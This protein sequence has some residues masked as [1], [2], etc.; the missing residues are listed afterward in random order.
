MGPTAS[1]KTEVAEAIADHFDAQLI[2]ADAF[3]VY[4]GMDIGTAK[5]ECK[6]R[7]RLLDLKAPNEGFGVG[8]FVQLARAELAQLFEVGR[9]AVVVG[10]TGLYIRALF[11]QYTELAPSP[12]PELRAVLMAREAQEGLKSLTDELT[13]R[14]PEISSRVDL[15]NPVRVRRALERL[16]SEPAQKPADLP[17]FLTTKLVLQPDKNE[18]TA[19]IE[20]RMHTMVQNGWLEEVE[21]LKRLGFGPGDPGFRA[22]G[23]TALWQ[24]LAGTVAL[25]DALES[26]VM[27]TRRYAKRQR[28]W[29]RSEPN[30]L[31]ITGASPSELISAALG[32]LVS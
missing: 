16:D 2:N 14:A 7:Y 23:Y 19:L 3:Q 29:L 32:T 24:H 28:S 21:S 12:A 26:T 18:L 31:P 9:S 17:P 22:L 11:E 1:G 6:S 4:R 13:R 5:P 15:A 10:G 8:E 27:D 30:A 25:K 20:I